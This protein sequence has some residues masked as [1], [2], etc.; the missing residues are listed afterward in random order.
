MTSLNLLADIAGLGVGATAT[1]ARAIA[2]GV[3]A[4]RS[5]EA[6]DGQPSW[7]DRFGHGAAAGA[8]A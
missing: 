6:P 4:A 7:Q 5:R 8:T 3:R 2:R 1:I